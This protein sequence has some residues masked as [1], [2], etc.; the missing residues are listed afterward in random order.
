MRIGYSA[1]SESVGRQDPIRLEEKVVEPIDPFPSSLVLTP[2]SR[3]PTTLPEET[4]KTVLSDSARAML[5]CAIRGLGWNDVESASI[6][7]VTFNNL[8]YTKLCLRSVLAHTDY[9]SYEIIIVDNSSTDGTADYLRQLTEQYPHIRLLLNESN[10]GFASA[11]NQGLAMAT[12]EMLILL[13]NDTIVPRGWLK[14]LLH[15][16]D[17]PAVGLVG[18]VTNRAGNESQIDVPYQTYGEFVQFAQDYLQGRECARF[19][20]RTLAMF[21]IALRRDVYEGI[22]PLDERFE[23][24]MFEDDDYAMR[25]RAAGYRVVNA[26]DVFVHHFGQASIGKLAATGEYGKLFQA[27]RRRFEEKWGIPWEPHRYRLNRQ[28]CQLTEQIREVVCTTLPLGAT[29]VVI[30]KGDDRL[31][32]LDGRQA[33]HFPR[34]EEGI[35]AGHYPADSAAA[36]THLEA[37]RVKGGDFLLLPKTAF[38]W[39]EHYVEFKQHLESH[40]QV[41]V[42][43]ADTCLVFAMREC[44]SLECYKNTEQPH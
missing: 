43:K 29:V 18:P 10:R 41:V 20:I 8:V 12:G 21:C 37:L 32:E 24:G 14:R 39:L 19:D 30:S 1:L 28:Y 11:N 13:N 26:E 34:T 9:P 27:N 40:Y 22:G 2:T 15:H 33:W 25:V 44:R 3:W 35:Y 23:I 17:D 42:R 6:I 31:L 38:W 36:I 7:I 16:L 5:P 4:I